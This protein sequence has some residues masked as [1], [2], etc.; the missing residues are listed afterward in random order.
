MVTQ[1]DQVS[2]R[3]PG[4]SV[5][6]VGP[7]LLDTTSSNLHEP[8][9]NPQTGRAMNP[10][11]PRGTQMT[12]PPR[13]PDRFRSTC[14]RATPGPS[15]PRQP[16]LDSTPSPKRTEPSSQTRGSVPRVPWPSTCCPDDRGGS[17]GSC[18]PRAEGLAEVDLGERIRSFP[19][20]DGTSCRQHES[21]R[22]K[23]GEAAWA[24]LLP[25][26]PR[27]GPLGTAPFDSVTPAWG[28]TG[29]R[30]SSWSRQGR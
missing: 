13:G 18:I 6:E 25:R 12:V 3:V 30:T 19:R 21:L 26:P 24:T 22:R 1:I 5:V 28:R 16:D 17:H 10:S 9:A 8:S 29:T 23:N 4:C 20:R 14:R 2:F 27:Q 11:A 15:Q 7:D